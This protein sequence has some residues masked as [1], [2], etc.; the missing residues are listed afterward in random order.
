MAQRN[1]TLSE[2]LKLSKQERKVKYALLSEK[3]KFAVRQMDVSETE[4]DIP[5]NCCSHYHGFSKCDCYPEN[6]PKTVI[7]ELMKNQEYQCSEKM[8]FDKMDKKWYEKTQE[9]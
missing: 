3:N 6:I 9:G 4:S 5:C 1:I 2:F 8:K 7:L